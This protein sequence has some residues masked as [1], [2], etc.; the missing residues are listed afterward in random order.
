MAGARRLPIRGL[1]VFWLFLL[2]AVAFLDRT[3]ISIAGAVI[4]DQLGID[5]I[6]LGWIFSS[7]LLGYAGF[8]VLGAGSPVVSDPAAFLPPESCGGASFPPL[9]PL[10]TRDSPTHFSS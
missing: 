8:Q 9:Q 6:H 3:N 7:F 2:S 1:L 4:R 5:N 10:R